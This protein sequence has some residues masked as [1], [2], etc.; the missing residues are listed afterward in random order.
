MHESKVSGQFKA[1]KWRKSI[2]DDPIQSFR[3]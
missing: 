1:E 3:D 2:L